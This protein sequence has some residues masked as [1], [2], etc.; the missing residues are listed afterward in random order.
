MKT[1]T[2]FL[3][4]TLLALTCSIQGQTLQKNQ[5]FLRSGQKAWIVENGDSFAINPK[6]LVVK[7]KAN[8]TIS[9]RLKKLKT[10]KLG[11]IDIQVPEGV[12][13]EDYAKEI[14]KSGDFESIE[15]ITELKFCMTPDDSYYG[16]LWHLDS[17]AAP[18]A[19]ELT[20]GSPSVKLAIID[21]GVD[22]GHYDLGY[23]NDS[24][25]HVSTIEGFDYINYTTYSTPT[26]GHGTMVAGVA[27]AKT[28]NNYGISGVTGGNHSSGITIIPYCVANT[29][30][31]YSDYIDDAIIDATGQGAK[32]INLSLSTST[33]TYISTAIG[34]AY[35]NGVTVVC[36]AG[37]DGFNNISFPASHDK[38]IAVGGINRN[39]ERYMSNYGTGLD[40]VAP[41]DS[42]I[43]TWTNSPFGLGDGT[44]LSAPQVSGA[45]ALMLSVNSILTPD[46]IRSILHN[47][48]DKLSGYTYNSDGW[49]NETGYG[50]LNVYEAVNAADIIVGEH[51][52]CGSEIYRIDN[53]PSNVYVVWSFLK[54]SSLNSLIQQ[55]YPYQNQCYVNLD[56]FETI[57]DTLC[58][59]IYYNYGYVYGIAKKRVSTG[60][61]FY[62]TYQVRDSFFELVSQ[63]TIHNKSNI[64][65]ESD[66]QV[67]I[68]SPF[69]S[70]STINYTT[71]GNVYHHLFNNTMSISF[72]NTDQ[73]IIV[74]GTSLNDCDNFKFTVSAIHHIIEP[75]LSVSNGQLTISFNQRDTHYIEAASCDIEVS[76]STTGQKV[77][78]GKTNNE[79]AV[80][81]T[82]NWPSGMYV[83]KMTVDGQVT[84][85]KIAIK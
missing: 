84:S 50:R 80:I 82:A 7:P 33:S 85:Q 31:P 13:V 39:N 17:I 64:I 54:Q 37:N 60:W 14:E 77:F 44:S 58:A 49:N 25:S 4:L 61:N 23:G 73:R 27:G 81:S 47:T 10:S 53:L 83:V 1:R 70:G 21:T 34:Y 19:W 20:T 30:Y 52:L 75:I 48:A 59:T 11:F 16:Y 55:N 65:V 78:S 12:L 5:T 68:Q 79:Q 40:L 46:E 69:F 3:V 41:N 22:A 66:Q 36:P 18:A 8:V 71:T 6:V 51:Q 35:D 26:D 62:G 32:V 28:N 57:D 63:G 76:N 74:R 9:S 38:T 42:I 24:Y 67:T 2:I 15:F 72:T 43:S 45:I 56:N 29:M